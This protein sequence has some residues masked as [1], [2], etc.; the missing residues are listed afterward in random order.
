MCPLHPTR[1]CQIRP[2]ESA[3]GRL[4]FPLAELDSWLKGT[5]LTVIRFS[6]IHTYFLIRNASLA[7]NSLAPSSS[8]LKQS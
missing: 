4:V 7:R 1:L 5:E 8:F 2:S 6:N 3:P